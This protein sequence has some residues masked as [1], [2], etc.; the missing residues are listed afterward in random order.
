MQPCFLCFPMSL[1]LYGRSQTVSIR[2]Y[3]RTY[4]INM[5]KW[6]GIRAGPHRIFVIPYNVQ[7]LLSDGSIK[8]SAKMFFRR[9]PFWLQNKI[10][11]YMMM[12]ATW[13]QHPSCVCLCVVVK[14]VWGKSAIYCK[15]YSGD[16]WTM[17]ARFQT[18]LPSSVQ[19]QN[20]FH[21]LLGNLPWLHETQYYNVA[22][23][24]T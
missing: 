3:W 20:A 14:C 23:T 7:R 15:S 1:C 10:P 6:H 2:L 5:T 8:P 19:A 17:L 18:S 24:T 4:I 9:K 12:K 16:Q 21:R 13:W 22:T 11:V